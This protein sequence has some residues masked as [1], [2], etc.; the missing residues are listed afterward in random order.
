MVAQ[1][2]AVTRAAAE[3]VAAASSQEF[4]KVTLADAIVA[5]AAPDAQ[6]LTDAPKAR[7]AVEIEAQDEPAVAAEASADVAQTAGVLPTAAPMGASIG[8]LAQASTE[9]KTDSGAATA[10]AD[11]G[12]AAAPADAGATTTTTAPADAAATTAA[13]A[14]DAAATDAAAAGEGG[15]SGWA[16]GGLAL[17]GVGAAVAIGNSG[18]SDDSPPAASPPPS[19]TPPPVT[20]PAPPPAP[21]AS[22]IP[23]G[24]KEATGVGPTGSKVYYKDNTGGTDNQIDAGERV[25]VHNTTTNHYYELIDAGAPITWE[26]AATQAQT[27][28]GHLFAGADATEVGFVQSTYSYPA[29]GA[30]PVFGGLEVNN[31][32]ADNGA[33]VGLTDT[34][35][36]V[37]DGWT[38]VNATGT[39]TGGVALADNSPLWIQRD[40]EGEPNGQ[41]FGAMTGGN[42]L[43]TAPGNAAQVLYDTD[44]TGTGTP[45]VAISKYVVEY[46]TLASIKDPTGN[47]LAI[48]GNS[49]FG[50]QG[51]ADAS[52]S[53]SAS[54]TSIAHLI[55]DPLNVA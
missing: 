37:A 30:A 26:N 50:S 5:N 16:I 19:T 18:S 42:S 14:A 53:V 12:A 15:M 39:T 29:A 17:L 9:S 23:T 25:I 48:E 41:T 1:V 27:R 33:W 31:I 22:T 46:E 38:W 44:N 13:P 36:G 52:M 45:A 21:P 54:A 28:G 11:S 43:T 6:A 47:A 10:P 24:F 40:L 2:K 32:D 7:V 51:G 4:D 55:D 8:E 3:Q 20:P 49:L 34:T 35:P